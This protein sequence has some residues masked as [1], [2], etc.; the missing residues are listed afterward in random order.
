MPASLRSASGDVGARP[1]MP[2]VMDWSTAS[3]NWVADPDEVV[4]RNRIL[5]MIPA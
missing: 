3:P 5:L 1:Q 4:D 2:A